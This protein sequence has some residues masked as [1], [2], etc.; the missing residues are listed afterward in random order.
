M[1]HEDDE[2]DEEEVTQPPASVEQQD[3]TLSAPLSK[4]EISTGA[5]IDENIISFE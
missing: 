4:P 5:N 1:A 2:F 3:E